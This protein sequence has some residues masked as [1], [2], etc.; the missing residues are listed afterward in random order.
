MCSF[1]VAVCAVLAC[2][3]CTPALYASD[4]GS[5][6]QMQMQST[7][8][9]L[10]DE[11]PDGPLRD[12][13][14]AQAL[15]ADDSFW[16]GKAQ[17]QL[18]L[19][20]YR[21]VFRSGYYTEQ[22]GPLPLPPQEVWNIT[23]NGHAKRQKI[24]NHDFVAVDY[25]FRSYIISDPASPDTVEPALDQDGGQWAE[26]LIFPIDPELLLERTG[27]ACMDE[28]EFPP[29]SVFEE[30][31]W[32]YYDQ[33]CTK[34]KPSNAVCHITQFPNQSCVQALDQ[35][36][37]KISTQILFTRVA[38]DAGI[39]AQ[40]RVGTIVNP[41]G[42]DLAVVQDQ[43]VDEEAI[44]YRY[45]DPA[46][47]EIAEGTV[48]A[49]GW[50]RLLAF[51][52]SV[53]NDGVQPIHMGDPFDPNNPWVKGHAFVYS[54]CHQHYHF[55]HYGTFQYGNQP[56]SKKAFCLEETN[57]YHNDESTPLTAVHQTCH[58]QGIGAGW[59]DEYNFGI[60][61]QWVDITGVDTSYPQPLT[62][63]SNPDQ[64]LCEGQTL[65]AFNNPVDP[66]DLND[67][68]FIFSGF[69]DDQNDKVYRNS[70][71]FYNNWNANNLGSTN[72]SAPN[73]GSFV[74]LPCT[75]GQTGPLRDC[76]FQADSP[77]QSC[78]PGKNVKLRCESDQQPKVLRTC[79]MSAA[80]G[81]G[82]ACSYG[83]SLS[84]VMVDDQPKDVEFACPVV[85]DDPGNGGG[86]S[87]Y[88]APVVG[89]QQ[90]TPIQC[91]TKK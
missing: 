82:V 10:L 38:Y 34:E 26:P 85:R 83:E 74:T 35:S 43:L 4:P 54:A 72:V 65:D 42:A 31:T 86:Y 13:A 20:D 91:V 87:L 6:V 61:G 59:G 69:Y 14:A 49:P 8:G 17:R 25:S 67:I 23:L 9:L 55:S 57:R 81:V 33:T 51:S 52:A 40:Y 3:W 46:S 58:Y 80:L 75:R 2:L 70:C 30:N 15:A 16:I 88:E 60:S 27:Y 5:L 63:L 66:L 1:W 76:G 71:A 39:A 53:R 29:G 89:D 18:R 48:G 77:L 47:C 7:V 22:K 32:Y 79:E 68:A 11:I 45:F 90:G 73:A 62:F 56:G 36:V 50:R 64:F 24:K 21:L 41:T 12:A 28:A 44:F 78:T 37:G 19:A 84:N